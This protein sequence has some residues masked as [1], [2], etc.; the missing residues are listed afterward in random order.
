MKSVNDRAHFGGAFAG[1]GLMISGSP[2]P[3]YASMDQLTPTEHRR[4]RR[5][6]VEPYRVRLGRHEG[7]LVDLSETGALVHLARSQHPHDPASDVYLKLETEDVT[8]TAR[9]VRCVPYAIGL[10]GAVWGKHEYRV[11]LEFI[12][13]PPRDQLVLRGFLARR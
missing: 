12:D 2:R 9:V 13:C 10:D 1:P 8:L 3:G 4:S 11:G 7:Y 5:V 6:R